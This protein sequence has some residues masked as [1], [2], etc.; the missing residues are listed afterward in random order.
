MQTAS[1]RRMTDPSR[2]P[3]GNG[4]LPSHNSWSNAFI[5][6]DRLT[7]PHPGPSGW[8][9]NWITTVPVA[10]G[11]RRFRLPLPIPPAVIAVFRKRNLKPRGV[12]ALFLA[13]LFIIFNMRMLWHKLR[14]SRNEGVGWGEAVANAVTG[15]ESSLVLGL[16]ELREIYEWEIK[17][18]N[19]PTRR[20]SESTNSHDMPYL[21]TRL[22]Y[23]RKLVFLTVCL[24]LPSLQTCNCDRLAGNTSHYPLSC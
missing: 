4:V 10:I 2:Y 17:S 23:R 8:S 12:L 22:K 3:N 16:D 7:G 5:D 15:H 14:A 11:H 6:K 19:Y 1:A 20:R 9:A 21:L 24:T 18:G 13:G